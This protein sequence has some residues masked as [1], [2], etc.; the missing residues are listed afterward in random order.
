MN[1]RFR[2]ALSGSC[3]LLAGVLCALYGQHVQDEANRVR[4]EALE[5]YGGEVVSL[6]VA[7]E[8]LEPGDV[9]DRSNVVERDWLADLAPTDA[10]TGID[11]VMGSEVTVP[12]AAG[13]PLTGLNFRDGTEA[14]EVPDGRVALSIPVTDKLGLP[15]AT[16]AGTMLAAYEVADTG[17]RLVAEGA[18]VLRVPG[19]QSGLSLSAGAVT[20]AVHPED[21]AQVLSA[22]AKGS[23]RLA[24][25][26]DGEVDLTQGQEEV[27]P[28]ELLP[29]GP[30][31][32]SPEGAKDGEAA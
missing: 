7:T 21:V 24:L 2:L 5:R 10:V 13:V 3:A 31:A 1:R 15:A 28:D 26:A 22:S 25:P 18:Q 30:A 19:E 8:G 6:V 11:A 14:V 27:A 23:L 4:T 9:V 32:G 17:V 29:E 16:A 12:V 20:L